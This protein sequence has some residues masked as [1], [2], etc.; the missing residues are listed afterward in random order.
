M[1]YKYQ[2]NICI[3][4]FS[5]LCMSQ[6]YAMNIIPKIARYC[7]KALSMSKDPKKYI[8]DHKRIEDALDYLSERGQFFHYFELKKYQA[9]G[10]KIVGVKGTKYQGMSLQLFPAVDGIEVDLLYSGE[11]MGEPLF[12]AYSAQIKYRLSGRGSDS[13]EKLLNKLADDKISLSE[14]RATRVQATQALLEFADSQLVEIRKRQ[15]QQFFEMMTSTLNVALQKNGDGVR[16]DGIQWQEIEVFAGNQNHTGGGIT[17]KSIGLRIRMSLPEGLWTRMHSMALFGESLGSSKSFRDG[18]FHLSMILVDSWE[19]MRAVETF[20]AGKNQSRADE[21]FEKSWSRRMDVY[22]KSEQDV[23]LIPDHWDVG[24]RTNL[25]HFSSHKLVKA[26]QP[27]YSVA[28]FFRDGRIEQLAY[29]I[30]LLRDLGLNSMLKFGQKQ[31]TLS[32]TVPVED[33][34][35]QSV[36]V[37]LRLP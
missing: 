4:V 34:S 22:P 9:M 14:K 16:V 13:I 36:L 26:Q 5:V 32:V 17:Q 12:K 19:F 10:P 31:N 8:E 15:S 6:S 2:K 21:F 27:K 28:E 29:P 3:I 25:I 20:L 11:G 1:K 7:E 35:Q 24:T 23:W 18:R 37:D 33:V 30:Y